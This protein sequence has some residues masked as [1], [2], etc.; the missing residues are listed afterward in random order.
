MPSRL[1]LLDNT[2]LTNFSLVHR[3]DLVLN[4]WGEAGATTPAVIAEYQAGV[5]VRDLTPDAWEGLP[6]ISLSQSEKAFAKTLSNTLGAGE[7]SCLAVAVH[8]QGMV[9]T[10]DADARRVARKHG[11]RLSGSLGILVLNTRRGAITL[12]KGNGLL[13]QLIDLGFRSPVNTLDDLVVS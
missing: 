8:R 10:D 3:V 12:A 7:T 6:V 1:V 4:L 13:E 11:L 5:E 2:V 9:A